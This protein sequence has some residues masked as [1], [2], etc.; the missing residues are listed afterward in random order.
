MI[1][2]E[3]K[4]ELKQMTLE[5][6]RAEV[7]KLKKELVKKKLDLKIGRLKNV[8]LI[9]KLRKEIALVLTLISEKELF[10]EAKDE[11]EKLKKGKE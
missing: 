11:A 10:E 1:K 9:K 8:K 3:R 5:E 2:K 4:K 7:G 6:L